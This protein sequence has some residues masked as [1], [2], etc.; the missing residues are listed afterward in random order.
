[1]SLKELISEDVRKVFLNFNDFAEIHKINGANILCVIDKDNTHMRS[2]GG[3]R[4][5]G[6]REDS[7]FV[8]IDSREF[9][10]K[11]SPH[12]RIDID[13]KSYFIRDIADENG[14]FVIQCG[15]VSDGKRFPFSKSE[16]IQR[17]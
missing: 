13:G 5:E 10:K 17:S 16:P 12:E 3:R 15:E 8:Y 9:V 14:I 4:T 11:P 7:F 2:S 1:M 6:V